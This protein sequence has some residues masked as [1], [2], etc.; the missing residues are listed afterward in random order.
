MQ[1]FKEN[2]SHQH[3]SQKKKTKTTT[4]KQTNKNKTKQKTSLIVRI[5]KY[6]KKKPH[7]SLSPYHVTN[8]LN[9]IIYPRLSEGSSLLILNETQ[10]RHSC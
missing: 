7:L 4:N 9:I 8:L 10:L 6:L 3:M 2:S 1:E 5:Q